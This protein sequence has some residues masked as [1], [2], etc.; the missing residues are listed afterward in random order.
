VKKIFSCRRSSLGLIGMFLLFSLGYVKG[1]DVSLAIS[2]IVLSIAGSNAY[3]KKGN[4]V[5]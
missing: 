5:E 1:A 2:G 4:P 3:E